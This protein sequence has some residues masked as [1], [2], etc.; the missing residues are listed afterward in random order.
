MKIIKKFVINPKRYLF[1]LHSGEQFY[2]AALLS[3]SD[4]TRLGQYGIAL[5]G[6]ARI[7]I[8]MRRL[9]TSWKQCPRLERCTRRCSE[10]ALSVTD[11]LL[12]KKNPHFIL[13]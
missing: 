2:I 7:S 11:K 13:H 5:N 12:T 1:T 9:W 4:R 6:A 8:C 10:A 3:D